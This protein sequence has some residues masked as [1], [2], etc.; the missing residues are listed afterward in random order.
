MR[1]AGNTFQRIMDHVLAGVACTFPYPD[2]IFI[3]SNGE[4]EHR[5]HLI[6]VLKPLQ[7]AGLAANME[8]CKFGKSDQDFL[9]LR[10]AGGGI[11]PLQDGSRPSWITLGRQT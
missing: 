8:K 1:N 3:F 2:N 5:A 7:E 11:K 4:E 10:I 9:G 6:V